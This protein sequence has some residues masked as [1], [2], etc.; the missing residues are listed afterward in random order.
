[1]ARREVKNVK[2]Q[3]LREIRTGRGMTGADVAGA[4]NISPQMYSYIETAQRQP[5]VAVAK[6]IAAVL[7]FDWT[8][9]YESP[10]QSEDSA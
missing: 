5:S 2:R 3:W 9:F 1:M 4:A 6:T 8:R 7:G 10:E